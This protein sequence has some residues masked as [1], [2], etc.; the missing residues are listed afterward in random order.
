VA[1]AALIERLREAQRQLEPLEVSPDSLW[2]CRAHEVLGPLLEWS[3]ADAALRSVV[4]ALEAGP[5]PFL[6][7]ELTPRRQPAFLPA[8]GAE[9]ARSYAAWPEGRP[10]RPATAAVALEPGQR[11]ARILAEAEPNAR[12]WPRSDSSPPQ[13]PRRE[14]LVPALPR[15]ELPGPV[16]RE[17]AASRLQSLFAGDERLWRAWDR[18]VADIPAPPQVSAILAERESPP[19]MRVETSADPIS[20]LLQ[21]VVDRAVR[22]PS[23]RTTVELPGS[24]RLR[25]DA[26]PIEAR[27]P[28]WEQLPNREGTSRPFGEPPQTSG[29]R[30]LAS[31]GETIE[32]ERVL[33]MPAPSPAVPQAAPPQQP[34][35]AF[36]RADL[37]QEVTEIFR[38]EAL[39]H[40]IVAEEDTP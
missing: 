34:R 28:H 3:G 24:G 20:V 31:Y 15:V 23:T 1:A 10:A 17:V 4:Q 37:A 6:D 40:G 29:L 9:R 16:N 30:R 13:S 38:R 26:T 35:V 19:M 33:S 22:Q 8:P 5:T 39:R 36:E 27:S 11:A 14:G 7:A 21:P 25:A 32:P 12:E 18:I 2:L